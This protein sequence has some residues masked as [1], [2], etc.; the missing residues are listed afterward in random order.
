MSNQL[1]S[2]SG[3]FSATLAVVAFSLTLPATRLAVA[4]LNPI[5]V[6]LGHSLV[7]TLL[8]GIPLVIA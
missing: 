8:A 7:A 3:Y 2:R 5:V 6:S 1:K 4:A